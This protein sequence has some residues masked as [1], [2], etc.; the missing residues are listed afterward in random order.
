MDSM[1]YWMVF[2][3]GVMSLP[4]TWFA[5]YAE[6]HPDVIVFE[7]QLVPTQEGEQEDV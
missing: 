4:D 6:A 3:D 1:R 2:G 5:E 7:A